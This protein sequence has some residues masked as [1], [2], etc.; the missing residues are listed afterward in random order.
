MPSVLE[1]WI[2]RNFDGHGVAI[3]RKEDPPIPGE[4]FMSMA[5]AKDLVRQA[6]Q[7]MEP[8]G[9]FFVERGDETSWGDNVAAEVRHWYETHREG[10][11]YRLRGWHKW[12]ADSFMLELIN[13]VHEVEGALSPSNRRSP[14]T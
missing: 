6:V 4:P 9:A 2:K 12:G 8:G 13:K 14:D 1:A 3:R 7:Q 10:W 11:W 5:V